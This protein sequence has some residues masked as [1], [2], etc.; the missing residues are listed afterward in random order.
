MPDQPAPAL[1]LLICPACGARSEYPVADPDRPVM[2][3]RECAHRYEF[4]RLPLFC[5]SGPS[6]SGKSTVARNLLHRLRDRMV[7]LEQDLLW[8][9]GLRDPAEEHRQFRSTWLRLAAMISQNGRPVLLCGTVVPIE[10]EYRAERPLLDRIHY[11]GLTC[12]PAAL[13]E[14]L[15]DRPAWRGWD[16]ERIAEALEFNDWLLANAATTSPPVDLLDTTHGDV[17]QTTDEVHAWV[18]AKL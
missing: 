9:A 7:V 5:L 18:H 4:L 12:E 15:A 11:L 14:R 3:C 17:E 8:M 1:D 10:L 16:E 2:T 13:R 6:G